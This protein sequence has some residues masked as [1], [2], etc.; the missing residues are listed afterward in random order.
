MRTPYSTEVGL[1]QFDS[2]ATVDL[3]DADGA[4]VP[5]LFAD[6]VPAP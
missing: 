6:V 1:G 5:N 2:A 4:T 3:T